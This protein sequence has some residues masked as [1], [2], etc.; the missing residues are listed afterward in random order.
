MENLVKL[1]ILAKKFGEKFE[2][3]RKLEI[4]AKIELLAYL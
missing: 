3:L 1:E 4:L 2:I